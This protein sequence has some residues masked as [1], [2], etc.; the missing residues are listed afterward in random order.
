MSEPIYCGL[1]FG[2]VSMGVKGELRPCCGMVASSFHRKSV[3][4]VKS[5][6]HISLQINQEPLRNVRKDLMNG[7]WHPACRIC[8]D[9]EKL[10]PESSMRAIWNNSIP[11][12]PMSEYIN[13]DNVKFL[14]LAVGNKCNSKCMTCNPGSSDFWIEEY[15]A[16]NNTVPIHEIY[17][18]LT[19]EFNAEI[20]ETFK[21]VEFINLIGGEPLINEDHINFL[22]LLV[23][24]KLSDKIN[25][26]YVTNL[27]GLTDEL[28]EVWDN[29]KSVNATVSI[30]GF[31]KV[32]DYIRYPI[33]FEKVQEKLQ[34]YLNLIRVDKFSI[35]LSSTV[36]IFNIN[37]ISELLDFFAV[38]VVEYKDKNKFDAGRATVYL[39]RV[40][41]PEHFNL[42]LL[43]TSYRQH[44]VEK[45]KTIREKLLTLDIHPSFLSA[46]DL[47][48][49]WGT[50]KQVFNKRLVNSA[51]DF[52]SKSD[53][54]RE[55]HI[56]DY[57]PD[58]WDELLSMQRG[59]NE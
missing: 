55:R 18:N 10:N 1:A 46:C 31:E 23:D 5:N 20:I 57:L 26:G 24:K 58:L 49:S 44:G 21:N 35:T 39:N 59:F 36:S 53:T 7:R 8:Q 54:F 48:E 34:Q 13:P 52:I 6:E 27:T 11:D 25:L 42:N 47:A 15:N 16:I 37:E 19:N 14:D 43:P 28:I 12:A 56:K 40:F 45:I 32:N 51:I 33:K 30:D 29:F 22:K 41:F 17:S 9:N 3:L 38:I 50:E 2:S 4:A